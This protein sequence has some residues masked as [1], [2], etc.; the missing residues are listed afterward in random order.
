ML[1]TF[2]T[3]YAQHVTD[4]PLLVGFPTFSPKSINLSINSCI[5]VG[6]THPDAWDDPDPYDPYRRKQL[7]PSSAEYQEVLKNVQKT[8]G[9]SVK[10]IIKVCIAAIL[11]SGHVKQLLAWSISFAFYRPRLRA[12]IAVSV[13]PFR[14]SVALCDN[15]NKRRPKIMPF[16]PNG[17]PKTFGDVA[18]I[19]KVAPTSRLF[20]TS[21]PIMKC[22]KLYAFSAIELRLWHDSNNLKSSR[23][24]AVRSCRSQTLLW[25]W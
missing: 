25:H 16:S 23:T 15:F 7:S 17:S 13:L 20:S 12:V 21:N 18:E 4:L 9:S 19:R 14:L 1:L 22:G 11:I 3:N 2:S 5:L 8:A 24:A 10:Q 6:L